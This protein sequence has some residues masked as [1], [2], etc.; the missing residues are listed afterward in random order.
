MVDLRLSA[1]EVGPMAYAG[2]DA[3]WHLL[4]PAVKNIY[5]GHV[6]SLASRGITSLGTNRRAE[7]DARS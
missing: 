1:G 7:G 2:R 4:F 6:G 5:T 3:N